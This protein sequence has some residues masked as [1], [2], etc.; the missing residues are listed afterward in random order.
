MRRSRC[1]ASSWA[2]SSSPTRRAASQPT[3]RRTSERPPPNSR[4]IDRRASRR[5]LGAP[6]STAL[7]RRRRRLMLTWILWALALAFVAYEAVAHFVFENVGM[8][9]FSHWWIRHEKAVPLLRYAT[10]V[11]LILLGVHLEGWL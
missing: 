3:H 1:S 9:T 4:S 11:L 7:V 8:E 5:P 2:T 10:P 6:Q